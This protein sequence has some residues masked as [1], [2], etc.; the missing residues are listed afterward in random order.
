MSGIYNSELE[1]HYAQLLG[2]P[3]PW[4]VKAVSL[5]VAAKRVEIQL[6]WPA[7]QEVSCPQCGRKCALYDHAPERTWRHLDTMQFETL[8]RARVPRAECPEH[9]VKT[10]SVAWAEPLGRFTKCFEQF[11]IELLLTSSNVEQASRLLGLS[12]DELHHILER[13]VE[14]GLSRRQFRRLQTIGLDEKSFGRGQAYISVLTDLAGARVLEVVPERTQAAAE[15]LLE[16]LPAETR[17][18]IQ[19]AALDMWEPF[20]LAVGAKLP[21]AELVHDR[22]HVAQHLNEAVDQVRRTEHKELLKAGDERLKGTR[23]LWLHNP[24]DLD[25]KQRRQLLSLCY[26]GLAVGRAWAA[27]ELAS[28]FWNYRTEGWARRCFSRWYRWV[29]RSRLKPMVKV[30]KMIKTHWDKIVSHVRHPIT[31]AV[32]EGL[33]SK[34]QALKSAARGFRNFANYRQRIL[35]FCGDLQLHPL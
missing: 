5:D 7:G 10:L 16:K 15:Q 22:F 32:T 14:R 24:Q 27:K 29:S 26:S 25:R 13:A 11:A 28:Q 4:R 6:E 18:Q 1:R 19:A 21:Q 9:G 23:Y 20:A 31:N 17:S 8:L 2:L 33:N 12:W 3:S 34:I 35:F 30:A